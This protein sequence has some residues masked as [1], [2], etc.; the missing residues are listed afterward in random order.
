MGQR[1]VRVSYAL[2]ADV[3]KLPPDAK[4]VAVSTHDRFDCDELSIKVES[5][6]FSAIEPGWCIPAVSP[7]YSVVDGRPQFDGWDGLTPAVKTDLVR[8]LNEIKAE[9]LLSKPG[10]E[11]VPASPPPDEPAVTFRE[12]L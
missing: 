3:L 2:L 5:P 10:V 11:V 8:Y 6:E 7:M 4:V 9:L 1:I 12:F